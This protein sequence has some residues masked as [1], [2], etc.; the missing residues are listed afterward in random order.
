MFAIFGCDRQCARQQS[1]ARR[2]SRPRLIAPERY[3]GVA[4]SQSAI[5]ASINACVSTEPE[6]RSAQLAHTRSGSKKTVVASS[7]GV[8]PKPGRTLRPYP[9]RLSMTSKLIVFLAFIQEVVPNRV[10]ILR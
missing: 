3:F 5:R 2:Q 10:A 6:L 4:G 9:T 7:P 8:G 1:G